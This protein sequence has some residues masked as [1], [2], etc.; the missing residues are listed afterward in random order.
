MTNLD[1]E[2]V[3]EERENKKL[4]LP[5]FTEFFSFGNKAAYERFIKET[6]RTD[7]TYQEFKKIPPAVNKLVREK[8]AT[9]RYAVRFPKFGLLKVI[10]TIPYSSQSG[11]SGKIKTR[12]DW[13]HYNKTKEMRRVPVG[14]IEGKVYRAYFYPYYRQFPVLGFFTFKTSSELKRLITYNVRNNKM[15][16]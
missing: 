4:K 5:K 6:G 12:P 15:A 16:Q 8:I 9:G 7:I 10:G 13:A 2:V 14:D 11:K 3:A 1:K